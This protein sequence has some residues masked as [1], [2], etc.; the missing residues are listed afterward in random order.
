MS[1]LTGVTE[2]TG[3]VQAPIAAP[4]VTLDLL[5]GAAAF[6]VFFAHMRGASFIEFGSLPPGQQNS[7]VALLFGVTRLGKEAVLTFFVLS[8]FLVGG[9]IIARLQQGSFDLPDYAI[10]RCSRILLPLIPTC[11]LTA[12]LNTFVLGE[13]LR[14]DDLLGNMVGINGVLV[15]SL[16]NNVPLWSLAYEIWFYIFAGAVAYVVACARQSVSL[17]ALVALGLCAVIFS[18][19][20]ARYLLYW[21]MGATMF[22]CLDIRWKGRLAFGGAVLAF[23]GTL[24]NQ[25]TL[26]SKSFVNLYLVPS[27]VSETL[28]CLGLCFALPMLCSGRVNRR[29]LEWRKFAA[30]IS[31][32]SY[33]LYLTH[34]PV[35][36]VFNLFLPQ[37]HS[38]SL[39]NILNFLIRIA[40]G[41]LIATALYFAFE[42]NT[43]ALRRLVRK[44]LGKGVG[45][46]RRPTAF[47]SAA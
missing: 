24:F 11:L 7:L 31:G 10:D 30:S 39:L 12:V 32:F 6:A 34:Y 13:P 8:G 17:V 25:L 40:G 41:L 19:L 47:A 44:R 26:Q 2:H 29:V 21:A 16:K 43:G 33:T 23:M 3:L 18:I 20:S 5:R 46:A 28:I 45:P 35:M 27:E 36:N 9:Q 14:W 1:D 15:T 22:M 42:R 4:L 38:L 37:G